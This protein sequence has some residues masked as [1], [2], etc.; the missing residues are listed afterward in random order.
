MS[1]N[2]IKP[3]NYLIDW[4]KEKKLNA[5]NVVIV[6]TDFGMAN[7]AGG[8]PIFCSPEN[9]SKTVPGI[10]DLFSLGR[11]F[12]R[13][14]MENKLMFYNFIFYIFDEP[15]DL[16]NAKNSL[17][18]FP[19]INLIKKMTEVEIEKRITLEKAD[20]LLSKI[21]LEIISFQLLIDRG[22]PAYILENFNSAESEIIQMK[23]ESK[24]SYRIIDPE[25]EKLELVSSLANSKISKELHDQG[26]FKIDQR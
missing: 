25:K 17:K 8:T 12:T 6:L 9:L 1:H 14:I 19:I 24:M 2:D 7:E 10:S 11:V 23:H 18:S 15:E 16:E 26:R 22:F 4:P 13:M 20:K 3:A 5:D 21:D